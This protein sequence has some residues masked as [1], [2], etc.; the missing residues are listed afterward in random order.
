ML[1]KKH[2]TVLCHIYI[3]TLIW[4]LTNRLQPV[5]RKW[6]FKFF[7]NLSV[8]FYLCFVNVTE[9]NHCNF[10]GVAVNPGKVTDSISNKK[11][12]QKQHIQG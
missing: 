12:E 4:L 7:E 8:E 11:S 9:F 1:L 6:W 2:I 10:F 3:F 5:Y